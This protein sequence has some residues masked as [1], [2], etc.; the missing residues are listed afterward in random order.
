MSRWKELAARFDNDRNWRIVDALDG[1]ARELSATPSQVALAWLIAQPQVSS[2][3]FGARTIAQLDDN[4]K[5]AELKLPAAAPGSVM[6]RLDEAA[7]YELGYPYE[8]IKA[9]QSRW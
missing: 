9:T 5:A 7:R 2:V 4:L 3:I 6:A 8:F 1:V